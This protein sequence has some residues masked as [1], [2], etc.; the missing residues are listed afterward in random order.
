MKRLTLENYSRLNHLSRLANYEEYNSNIVTMLMWNHYYKIYY[1]LFDN[2]ALILVEYPNLYAWLMPLCDKKYLKEAFESMKQYSFD[3]N[4]DFVV[5]GLTQ[6]VKEYCELNGIHFIYEQD[7]DA[8]DYVYD[9]EMHKTLG[10]KKMQKRRNHFNAFMKEYEQRYFYRALNKDDK[11]RVLDFLDEWMQS[12]EYKE[13]IEVEKIGISY[14]FDIFEKI[15]LKG[16]CIFVD[17]IL[18][19]FNIYSGLS[20]RMLQ[21]HVEKVDKSIRG[22]SCALLKFTLQNCGNYTL[23]NREDDM[24]LEHLRKAKKDMNPIYKIKKYT[25]TYGNTKIVNANEDDLPMIKKLWLESFEDE[26]VHSSNFYF[27]YLYD[28]KN[29]FLLKVNDEILSMLQIRYMDIM[30]DH[31]KINVG[32]IFGVA[33]NQKYQGCGYMKTLLNHVLK[34]YSENIFLI[35][36]YNWD[37]YQSFG[38]KEAYTYKQSLFESRGEYNGDVC[39]DSKH[40]LSIYKDYVMDKDG[41]RIRDEKYYDEFFIPY[42]KPYYEIYANQDAYIVVDKEYSYIFE[43]IYRNEEALISLLNRF[44]K[45]TVNGDLAFGEYKKCHMLM[46]NVLFNRNDSLF[47]HES[48]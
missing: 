14:L 1:E 22:L 8:Q 44:D 28:P 26:D 23:M 15:D 34:K 17:G 5:H 19:G 25:A 24:G 45:I 2:Y 12:S 11:K 31:E 20:D 18:K 46:A 4:I 40:L 38:F 33:T 42:Y 13:S 35:Q 16:G 47:I 36:A 10:G 7:V 48:I 9:I 3:H 32:L 41:Y 27:D 30:K 43:C 21:M 37:I 39:Y 6:D 29:T